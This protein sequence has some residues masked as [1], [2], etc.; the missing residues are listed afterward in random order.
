MQKVAAKY[1]DDAESAALAA[2]KTE[3]LTQKISLQYDKIDL[4]SAGLDEAA[5]KYGFG[6]VETSKW[7]KAL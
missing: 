1:A 4:L 2:A 7:Q 6:S 3:L 5:E